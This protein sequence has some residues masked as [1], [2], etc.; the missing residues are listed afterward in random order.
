VNDSGGKDNGPAPKWYKK[1]VA[2]MPGIE[3]AAAYGDGLCDANYEISE[4]YAQTHGKV[5]I[6]IYEVRTAY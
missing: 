5:R 1:Q 2:T 3:Q 4:R 6:E